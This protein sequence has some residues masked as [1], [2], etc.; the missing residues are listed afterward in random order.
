AL[1]LAGVTAVVIRSSRRKPYLAMGWF[2]YLGTL[3][4]VIGIVQVGAQA[5]ADRYTY[6]PLIGLFI[7]IAWGIPELATSPDIHKER[8]RVQRKSYSFALFL[9]ISVLPIASSIVIF[10]MMICAYVQ[11]SYWKNSVTL[12]T[13]SLT[14]TS[15]N[16]LAHNNLG[17]ALADSDDVDA[18]IRHYERA[19]EIKPDFPLAHNNMGLA[20]LKVKRFNEA[21]FHFK[22]ALESEP[23]S[24][25]FRNN[26][27]TALMEQGMLDEAIEQFK[28]ALR[29]NPDYAAAY[30]NMG[31]ALAKLG[32]FDGAISEYE[33]SLKLDP[34]DERTVINLGVAL[35]MQGKLDSA[36]EVYQRALSLNP[37]SADIHNNLGLAYASQGKIDEALEHYEEAIR[38]QPNH[39]QAHYNLAVI[40]AMKGRYAEAWREVRL[41][42]QYGYAVNPAFIQA[43]SRQMRDPRAGK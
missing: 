15:N 21:I 33:K 23:N 39:G 43:L 12:F 4:P 10:A 40:L 31:L 11:V 36:V 2:W 3:I 37:K 26:Y 42:A 8:E 41:S 28:R 9:R 1:L 7:M 19:L 16:A 13:H 30:T 34:H 18:A 29:I 17:L 24:A 6:I 32:D 22:E 35:A 38:I 5:M 25:V 27:G 14:S 20:L